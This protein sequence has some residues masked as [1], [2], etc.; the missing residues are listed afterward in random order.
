M[1][2]GV[3]SREHTVEIFDMMV[4]EISIEEKITSFQP[5][6]IDT[7]EP[8]YRRAQG[9]TLGQKNQRT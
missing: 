2:Y 8:A 6:M 7:Y 1:I 4:E 9:K 3:F 5:D